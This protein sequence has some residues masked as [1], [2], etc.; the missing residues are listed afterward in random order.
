MYCRYGHKGG[1]GGGEG[2]GEEER[3]FPPQYIEV[4]SQMC[5]ISLVIGAMIEN[6]VLKQEESC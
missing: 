6:D 2:E 5:T 4:A 3:I 1:E